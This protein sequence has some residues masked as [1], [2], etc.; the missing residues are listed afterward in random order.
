M[1]RKGGLAALLFFVVALASPSAA[2][3][4]GKFHPTTELEQH[5][6]IPIHLGALNCR[7]RRQSST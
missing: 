6:W 7:S 4:R 1:K 3:A 2:L 5:E